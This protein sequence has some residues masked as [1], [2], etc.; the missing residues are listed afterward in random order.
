MV[1]GVCRVAGGCLVLA[2]VLLVGCQGGKPKATVKGK[3]TYKGVA[4]TTGSVNFFLPSKGAGVSANLDANGQFVFTEPVEPGSYKVFVQPPVLEPLP[5]GSK[6][7]REPYN[8]PPKF[9]DAT[10]T[11]ISKE[12]KAGDN[13]IPVEL[14]E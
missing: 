2:M 14:T 3:V 7:K 13:D 6:S 8:I 11:P 1:N 12:V 4:V 5:P 9:Q 10:Q